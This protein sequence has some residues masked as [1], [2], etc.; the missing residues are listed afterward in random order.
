MV[1]FAHGGGSPR[2]CRAP[3]AMLLHGEG[4]LSIQSSGF[5]RVLDD[6]VSVVPG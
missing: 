2:T 4:H 3:G 5:G 6:L 1:P